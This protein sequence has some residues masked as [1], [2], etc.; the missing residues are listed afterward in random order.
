[1]IGDI[2]LKLGGTALTARLE[3]Q[4]VLAR[5]LGRLWRRPARSTDLSG[6]AAATFSVSESLEKVTV[7]FE[8]PGY[9]RDQLCLEATPHSVR[10][11]GPELSTEGRSGG[12]L[13]RLVPLPERVEPERVAASLRDGLLTVDLPKAAWVRGKARRVPIKP[14]PSVATAHHKDQPDNHA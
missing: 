6:A 5:G 4:G 12:E 8:V 9:G 13:D 10:L 3:Y 2:Q 14:A 1:M 11:R 7:V